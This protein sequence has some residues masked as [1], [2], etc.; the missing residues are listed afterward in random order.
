MGGQE[1]QIGQTYWH[2][3]VPLL[4]YIQHELWKHFFLLNFELNLILIGNV[5]HRAASIPRLKCSES[6]NL[7]HEWR[8]ERV[9]AVH[10]T[11]FCAFPC[12]V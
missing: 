7:G 12:S 8:G 11:Y 5:Y 1:N 10:K 6:L 3:L 9:V 2:T 4:I